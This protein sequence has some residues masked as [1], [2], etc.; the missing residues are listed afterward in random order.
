M[1]NRCLIGL[2]FL[3]GFSLEVPAQSS[4]D[5]KGG[6]YIGIEQDVLPYFLKGWIAC[7][8]VGQNKT[9]LRIAY[10]HATSPDLFNPDGFTNSKTRALG[11]Q[12]E[13]F[14]KPEFKG[15]WVGPGI[16]YWWNTID[17]EV[18]TEN[19]SQSFE[20]LI[21]SLG[22]GYNWYLWKGLY[23]SPW[24]AG[25]LRV[26]GNH[27]LEFSNGSFTPWRVTPEVSV[28]VGWRFNAIRN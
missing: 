22:G 28:K 26:S 6:T 19:P 8:W 18:D 27:A 5:T 13:Q 20:S 24:V 16:G 12:F 7:A 9:R 4:S 11:F 3:L 10:A 15:F 23:V 14:F 17:S 1:K 21:I 2:V 25:H